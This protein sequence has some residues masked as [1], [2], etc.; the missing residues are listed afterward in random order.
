MR[1]DHHSTKAKLQIWI[2]AGTYFE[3][4]LE[5]I[6]NI[7]DLIIIAIK[8]QVFFYIL[9]KVLCKNSKKYII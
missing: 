3:Y 1:N 6:L 5:R 9:I 4:K 2:D 8:S 7:C